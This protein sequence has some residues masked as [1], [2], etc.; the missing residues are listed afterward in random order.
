M[1]TLRNVIVSYKRYVICHL[2]YP[3]INDVIL[4]KNCLFRVSFFVHP[5]F[6]SLLPKFS[7]PDELPLT[8]FLDFLID[9]K[10]T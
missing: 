10:L 9:H 7:D 1:N 8:I 2:F 4:K 5:S 6:V 3:L